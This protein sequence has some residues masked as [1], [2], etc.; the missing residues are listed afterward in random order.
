MK[1][2]AMRSNTHSNLAAHC[3]TLFPAPLFSPQMAGSSSQ[4]SASSSRQVCELHWHVSDLTFFLLASSTC[5]RLRFSSGPS[6]GQP[7]MRWL[8]DTAATRCSE[9]QLTYPKAFDSLH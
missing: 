1:S 7:T 5:Q 8:H 6:A 2:Y 9:G 3:L 4:K